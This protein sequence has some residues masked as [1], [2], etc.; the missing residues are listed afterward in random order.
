MR[1]TR[2]NLA[3][4][5][6]MAGGQGSLAPG[7]AFLAIIGMLLAAPAV[8]AQSVSGGASPPRVLRPSD[9]LRLTLA[10][11][12]ALALRSNPQLRA[13]R[14]DIDVAR[15]ELRQASLLVRS[16]PSA[17]V[18]AGG[19]GA[20]VGVTQEIE[21][22][23]QRGARR[24]AGRAGVDRAQAGVLNATRLTVADVDRAFYRL[25]ANRQRELLANEVLAL[26]SRLAD[27]AGR[28]LAAGDISQLDANLGTVEY[29][30]SRSR[31]LAAR[32]ERQR[33]ESELRRLVGVSADT[34]IAPVADLHADL[35]AGTQAGNGRSGDSTAVTSRVAGTSAVTGV[36]SAPGDT[37]RFD[38]LSVDSLTA[39]ALARR[40]DLLERAAATRQ[41]LALASVARR[42]AFPNLALRGSSER[43]EGGEGRVLRPGIGITLPAF[44]RNQGEVE[45][46]RA[47]ARQTELGRAAL[48]AGI[49]IDVAQAVAAYETAADEVDVLERTVLTPARENR[50]LL[51]VAYRAGKVGLPVLLLI[52]NQVIDAELEYWDAWLSAR[53]ALADLAEATG[54]TVA[55]P[56][57]G[58]P[59]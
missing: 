23:G 39:L 44:N 28:Q 25:T 41:A 33:A 53:E 51:E 47:E 48:V 16:N 59:R 15:G 6:A 1:Q 22:A 46:R 2:L 57:A 36:R 20:E 9:T 11:A 43:L 52:R 27:V 54:A 24:A 37:L 34:P 55:P 50:R 31:A 32:R 30:R 5:I 18:L 45:A 49:R 35:L 14:L 7:V 40:P 17:D 26:N 42:E 8:A 29:G 3:S 13:A 38:S 21:V 56:P 4:L 12:R 58:A 19:T 10:D